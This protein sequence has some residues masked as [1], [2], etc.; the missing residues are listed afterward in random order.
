MR[1]RS[2]FR[3]KNLRLDDTAYR[4]CIKPPLTQIVD[5]NGTRDALKCPF[6]D[7]D[8]R[9]QDDLAMLVQ[10]SFL[11]AD[12]YTYFQYCKQCEGLYAW[13]TK[14]EGENE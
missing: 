9:Y 4:V 2:G 13:I 1:H 8:E 14:D 5:D 10:Y 11:P 12:K 7:A 3:K 6:C